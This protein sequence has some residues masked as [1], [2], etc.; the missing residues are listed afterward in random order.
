M[1]IEQDIRAWAL[2]R[3]A[4]QQDVLVAV[5]RGETYDAPEPIAELADRLLLPNSSASSTAAQNLTL[6][7][8]ELKQV[9]LKNVCNVKGVN[10]L[11]A[12]QTLAFARDGLT[13]IYGNNGSG[14]SGYARVIKA[15]VSARHSSLVLPDAYRDGA[16]DPSAELE[17]RVDDQA[18]SDKFPADPP[19]PDLQRVRFYDEHCGDEYL[20]RES[21]VTYRPSS[22]MLLDGLIAVCGKVRDELQRRIAESNHK[23]LSL[24]LPQGTGASTFLARL[25]VGTTD[26]QIDDACAFTSVDA[27]NLGKAIQEVAR[28]ETSDATKERAR[29]QADA[30]QVRTLQARLTE[31]ESAVSTDHLSAIGKLKNDAATKRA[32]ATVAAET[33]FDD[34]PLAGV[35]S[36]T[37]RVLWRAARD[38]SVSVSDHQHEFPGV[39]DG[40]RCVLCQQPLG[41][42]AKDRFTRFNTYMTDTTQSDAVAAER[43]YSQ[44]LAE[45][46]SLDFAT[47]TTT[48]ALSA[49]QDHDEPLA[50]EVQERLSTLEE[51]RDKALEHLTADAPTAPPLAATTLGTQLDGLGTSLKTKAD[52]TDVAGFQAALTTAKA[53]RD[54]LT[55]SQRLSQARLELKAEVARRKELAELNNAHAATDTKGITRKSTEL[56]TTYATEQIR[57][58]FTRETDRMRLNKVTLRDL[59][60]QKGQVRQIPALVGVRHK[61]ATART[62]LSEGEQTVLGLAGFCTEAEFDSSKSAVVFDDPVTSLDHVRRDK[63]AERLAQLA[64]SRQV[65]VFTHDVAFVSDLLR[66]ASLAEVSIAARTIQ[67]RGDVPGY[68][69]D[70]FPWKAQDIGQR[71]NTIQ[72]EITQLSKERQ[73]LDDVE[74]EKRVNQVAGHLSETW[75]RTV[76][77]EIINRVYDRSKSEV[78]PQ[79]VRMLAKITEDDNNDYQEGY[80]KTSKWA[81][82]HDKAEETNYVPPESS[83]LE[84]EYTRLKA[85]HKRIRSYQQ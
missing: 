65:I 31:L 26:Q 9:G 20:S 58:N 6:G 18:L 36:E 66:S 59:G 54:A 67:H 7:A 85:W 5:S 47:Q 64:K 55:A 46:R 16:P 50:V 25:S 74:Y 22:L 72:G 70:G 45:L 17:Y 53:K 44:A 35:G 2:T 42:D 56:T 77:S 80:G 14:K 49:L 29:L 12:D 76:T 33:S 32:A 71:M 34:E 78:R 73:N 57:D 30:G 61:D 27:D 41:D 84:A 15:M 4:W 51:R 75:E 38:Y 81:L 40:A 68:V 37:W 63:V 11:A 19:V 10:A 60:G 3:P 13:I 1:T 83:E 48:A 69:A 79:M 28:L 21:S 24:V 43:M 52:A 82:R 8:A 62:V 39:D 23:R